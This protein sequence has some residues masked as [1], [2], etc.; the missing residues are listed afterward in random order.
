MLLQEIGERLAGELGALVGVEY[1]RPSL[2]E[3]LLE[4]LDT[5]AGVQ[6]V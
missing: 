1:L 3:R 6:G 4:S 5:E 2:P